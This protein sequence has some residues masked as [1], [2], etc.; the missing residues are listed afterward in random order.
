MGKLGVGFTVFIDEERDT[1]Q[2]G[3][4]KDNRKQRIFGVEPRDHA[5]GHTGTR[6]SG[7][8]GRGSRKNGIFSLG[9]VGFGV[10]LDGKK[11]FSGDDRVARPLTGNV[12]LSIP[13]AIFFGLD[14]GHELEHIGRIGTGGNPKRKGGIWGVGATDYDFD[15]CLTGAWI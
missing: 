8:L 1:T 12:D 13:G 6:R 15:G 14:R 2:D 11:I 4:E 10:V 3:D 9:D 5:F 7:W